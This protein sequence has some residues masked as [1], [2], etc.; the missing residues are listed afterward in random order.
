MK[1][2]RLGIV[3]VVVALML[4]TVLPVNASKRIREVVDIVNM[5]NRVP[6]ATVTF[7]LLYYSDTNCVVASNSIE[8]DP[9]EID[10]ALYDFPAY[11]QLTIGS[12][13]RSVAKYMDEQTDTLSTYLFVSAGQLPATCSAYYSSNYYFVHNSTTYYDN[14][15]YSG[16]D[17]T[18]SFVIP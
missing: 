14:L 10:S 2:K 16:E 12:R 18:L 11:I 9:E 1:I 15:Y 5:N 8:Y 6:V 3:F 4:V 17:Y 13:T 7:A